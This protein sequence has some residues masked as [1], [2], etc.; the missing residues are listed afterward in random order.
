MRA[1]EFMARLIPCS[2]GQD[3]EVD[4]CIYGHHCPGTS[5]VGGKPVCGTYGCRFDEEGHPPGTVIKHP[6]SDSY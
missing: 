5:T 3:C 1:L 6:R 2:N 4:T